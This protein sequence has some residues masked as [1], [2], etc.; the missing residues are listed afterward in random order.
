M[1]EGRLLDV[2]DSSLCY[3]ITH[4]HTIFNDMHKEWFIVKRN[5]KDFRTRGDIEEQ[6]A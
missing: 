2:T 3:A 1:A 5:K 6:K 4:C